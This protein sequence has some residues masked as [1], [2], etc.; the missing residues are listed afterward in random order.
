MIRSLGDIKLEHE[1]LQKITQTL[2][3]IRLCSSDESLLAGQQH[4]GICGNFEP[5]L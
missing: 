2:P 5:Q 4:A 3:N 1:K